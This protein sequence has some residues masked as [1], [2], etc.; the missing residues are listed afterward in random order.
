MSSCNVRNRNVLTVK[1]ITHH[2][3]PLSVGK[4]D[5]SRHVSKSVICKS[6]HVKQLKVSKSMSSCNVGNPNVHV[7]NGISHHTKPLSAGKSY[8]SVV[9]L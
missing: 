3:K 4:S 6:L 7:V 9:N 2:T 5:H 8:C 1:N